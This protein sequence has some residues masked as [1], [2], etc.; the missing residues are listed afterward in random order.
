MQGGSLAAYG[1]P[2]DVDLNIEM[3]EPVLVLDL[4]VPWYQEDHISNHRDM[5]PDQL[6]ATLSGEAPEA[7][8]RPEGHAECRLKLKASEVLSASAAGL[9]TLATGKDCTYPDAAAEA[10]PTGWEPLIPSP[11]RQDQPRAMEKEQA[12]NT[13]ALSKRSR[14][15]SSDQPA[16][17][18][19]PPLRGGRSMAPRSAWAKQLLQ[20]HSG[21][22]CVV[23][24]G[25]KRRVKSQGTVAEDVGMAQS[26]RRIGKNAPRRRWRSETDVGAS[27]VS[28]GESK[29]NEKAT[30]AIQAKR[31]DMH[32][33]DTYDGVGEHR[34]VASRS[35]EGSPCK[36]GNR[37]YAITLED[38]QMA[39]KGLSDAH[40]SGGCK[41]G[42]RDVPAGRKIQK[43]VMVFG[44]TIG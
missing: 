17:K 33:M 23:K 34:S 24:G 31:E 15:A 22:D 8:Q 36:L 39:A 29:G 12:S 44:A 40:T 9:R 27:S 35:L 28:E 18:L 43:G 25:R 3:S 30:T 1:N 21:A 2:P 7:G 42:E 6:R 19:M 16:L 14:P 26:S 20:D 32:N 10:I 5:T 37:F 13:A 38:L 4:N 41:Q 11:S